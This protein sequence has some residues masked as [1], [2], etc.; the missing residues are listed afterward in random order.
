MASATK[1]TNLPG[2]WSMY[3]YPEAAT[4]T[5]N[6]TGT[7]N[8]LTYTAKS[9]STSG[10]SVTI[11][12]VVAGANTPLT[13]SVTGNAITVNVATNGS[14]AATS[15]AAQ[16]QAAV[17]ASSPAAALVS[18]ANATGND[19]TGVVTA[20]SVQTLTG[21]RDGGT[22]RGAAGWTRVAARPRRSIF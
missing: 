10:N 21:G 1:I 22:A 15:T 14:S 8:D 16:V 13:V 18:A 5:T 17:A 9:K 3:G 19:G 7:N 4:Y 11:T 2:P 12:Y 20:M 6:L